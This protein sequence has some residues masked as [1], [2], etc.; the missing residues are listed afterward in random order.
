MD[1]QWGLENGGRSYSA[2]M[3]MMTGVSLGGGWRSRNASSCVGG[4]RSVLVGRD[5]TCSWD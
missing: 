1:G 3:D 5:E 2:T 4:L